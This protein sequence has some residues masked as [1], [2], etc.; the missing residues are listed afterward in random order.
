MITLTETAWGGWQHAYTLTNGMIDVIFPAEVGIRLLHFGFS[1]QPGVLATNPAQLG[2]TGGDEWRI[3]GGHRLWHAPEDRA[4]TYA[5]DNAPIQVQA[6]SDGVRLTQSVE[7]STGIAKQLEISMSPDRAE[8]TLTHRLTNTN[9]WA[10][11]C[12]A[13]ALSVM[14][15]DGTAILP[16]PPYRSHTDQ[17]TPAGALVVWAY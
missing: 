3:Y 4:R 14:Q 6:L 15:T 7:A 17:L 16:L 9:L 5:P 13:W 2:M 12:A 11:E 1:G 8:L 10:V